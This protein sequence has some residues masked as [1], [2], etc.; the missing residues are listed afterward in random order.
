L[1]LLLRWRLLLLLLRLLLLLLPLLRGIRILLAALR[2]GGLHTAM[3]LLLQLLL[4]RGPGRVSRTGGGR[5]SCVG[6]RRIKGAA[7]Q[8]ERAARSDA[9]V[10]RD[11]GRAPTKAEAKALLWLC[12]R[13]RLRLRLR[14]W[15]RLRHLLLLL[16]R[17]RRGGVQRATLLWRRVLLVHRGLVLRWRLRAGVEVVGRGVVWRLGVGGLLLGLLGS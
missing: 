13:L 12:L 6:R 2:I 17:H 16:L 14:L 9:R 4:L 8:L 1:R 7:S 5:G 15:L 3:R 10:E 11:A